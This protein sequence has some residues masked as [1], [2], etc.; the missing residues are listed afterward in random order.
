[1]WL[2][3]LEL[4]LA[5]EKTTALAL[6]PRVTFAQGEDGQRLRLSYF[7]GRRRLGAVLWRCRATWIEPWE[8]PCRASG[9]RGS[10]GGRWRRR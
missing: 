3:R 4:P 2:Q 1:M 5:L 10:R 8:A 6:V 7:D 9:G